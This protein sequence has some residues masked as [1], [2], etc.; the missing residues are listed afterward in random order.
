MTQLTY[1]DLENRYSKFISENSLRK[2]LVTFWLPDP[3]YSNLEEDPF[4]KSKKPKDDLIPL[5][6]GLPNPGFFPIKSMDLHIVDHPF[7][8]RDSKD[9]RNIASVTKNDPNEMNLSF[10]LQYGDTKGLSPLLDFIE[11]FV[12][13][14]GN[15]PLY[16]EWDTII[17]NG[18]NDSLFKIFETLA[19]ENTTVMVEE[20][21]F[22]PVLSAVYGAGAKAIPI[23]LNIPTVNQE[24]YQKT[25]NHPFD[26]KDEGIDVDY[27]SDLLDNW[28]TGPYK[29]LSKPT[30]LYTV[31]TG[32]NPTGVTT[33][34][35]KKKKI[36]EL[37]KIH[38]FIIIEDDPYGYLRMPKFNRLKPDENLYTVDG[39]S[40]KRYLEE[41]MI[42]SYLSLDDDGRVLR[43]ETF[44]KVFSPGLR[45]SF[46]SGNKYLIK[47]IHDYTDVSTRGASSVSQSLVY[48][49][50]QTISKRDNKPMVD[51]WLDWIIQV[52]KEYTD[53]RNHIL[54]AAYE[55]ESFKKGYFS[56][57]EPSAGM[58]VDFEINFDSLNG[59]FPI[60]EG[61]NRIEKYFIKNGLGVVLG[62]KMAL[63]TELSKDHCG[64]IRTAI[65]FAD[66]PE[67]LVEAINRLNTS[68][69]EFFEERLKTN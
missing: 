3:K 63:D 60:I 59:E 31:T 18:S 9:A 29:H 25:I 27:L 7:D 34:M 17:A 45:L 43:L 5:S 8:E 28:S 22:V 57:I 6:L 68:C 42:K 35:E 48:S 21:T 61:M 67:D 54:K 23:K 16:D 30:L 58:F 24:N 50:L 40:R 64:L 14:V 11:E 56:V 12:K 51:A 38:D 37:A 65:S 10:V 69:I 53:R 33:Y 66:K 2:K 36:M 19:D 39:F 55:T 4:L 44:S 62:Y 49:T 46:I 32:Q 13:S 47:Q 1:K 52:A 41:I 15:Q 26:A 20:F